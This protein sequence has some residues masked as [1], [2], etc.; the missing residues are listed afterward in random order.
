MGLINKFNE[1]RMKDGV[2]GTL[3][4]VGI[5]MPDPTA[6]SAN[7]RLDGVVAAADLPAT[8]VVHHGMCSAS[9]W[10]SPGDVLPVTVDR[11]KP[12]RLVI[13]WD[14]LQTGKAKAQTAA[15]QLAEQMRGGAAPGGATPMPASMPAG[16]PAP[17][18]ADGTPGTPP[19]VVS[20]ADIL[21]RGTA[22]TAAVL[23]VFP[24]AQASLKPNHTMVGLALDVAIPGQLPFQVQNLYAVP[25]DKVDGVAAGITVPVKA[26]LTLPGVPVAVDWDAC[27]FG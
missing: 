15:Q 11:A 6:T 12:E 2:D 7:Y 19:P 16:L 13:H 20:A 22:G 27:T 3:T 26:E 21:A 25:N 18:P 17:A 4:V 23:A 5:T 24:T 10:P 1:L 14:R 9:R 8:P